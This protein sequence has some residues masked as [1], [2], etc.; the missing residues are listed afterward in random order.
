MAQTVERE[1]LY[2]RV[3][4]PGD[5]IPSHVDR[6]PMNNDHSADEELRRAVKRSRNGRSGGVSKIRAED[7]KMWL[8]GV[9]NKEKAREK[10]EEGYEYAGI[11]TSYN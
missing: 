11:S 2:T 1:K 3:P 7:L 6:P 10:G 8:K 4:T 9:E 5:K